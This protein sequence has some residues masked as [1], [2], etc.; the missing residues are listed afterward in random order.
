M[1]LKIVSK[2]GLAAHLGLLAAFPIALS[3]FLD[4]DTLGCVL[5]WLSLFAAIWVFFNP[6][7]RLGEHSAD[8]RMRVFVSTVRDPAFYFFVVA[9]V[10]GHKRD[11]RALGYVYE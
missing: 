4:A 10:R 8:A 7:V 5:L 1:I 3:Q 6:S 2:Y 11:A 9:I